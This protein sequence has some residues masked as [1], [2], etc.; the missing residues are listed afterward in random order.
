MHATASHP[1]TPLTTDQFATPHP[2]SDQA[3]RQAAGAPAN[4]ETA[5][6]FSITSFVLGIAS[7]VSGWTFFVPIAG[8]IFG[9]ISLR[10]HTT[11]RTLALWGVW[12]N[13]AMLALSAL[14]VLAVLAAV[15]LGLFAIPFVV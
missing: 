13:A 6:A 7:V 9:I 14:L 10:R 3:S 15:A 8:L 5:R 2:A 1:T 4:P 11:E 12:L